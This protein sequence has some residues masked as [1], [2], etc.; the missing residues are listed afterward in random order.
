[1]VVNPFTITFKPQLSKVS[2][3]QGRT[4]NIWATINVILIEDPPNCN[5]MT[6]SCELFRYIHSASIRKHCLNDSICQIIDMVN[7]QTHTRL[8]S[9]RTQCTVTSRLLSVEL[10]L[11]DDGSLGNFDSNKISA[12]TP[13]ENCPETGGVTRHVYA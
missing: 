3:Q 8:K 6:F 13:G 11:S 4:K 1:M 7:T 9:A 12:S 2:Q 5:L 10:N